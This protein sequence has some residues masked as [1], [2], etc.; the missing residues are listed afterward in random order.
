MVSPFVVLGVTGLAVAEERDKGPL[1]YA[2]RLQVWQEN[3]YAYFLGYQRDRGP[4]GR[5]KWHCWKVRRLETRHFVGVLARDIRGPW[6][7]WKVPI[8]SRI[9]LTQSFKSLCGCYTR[10]NHTLEQCSLT[11]VHSAS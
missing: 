2:G 11:D 4:T 1:Q 8:G 3:Q 9:G 10:Q 5:L 7:V 6:K